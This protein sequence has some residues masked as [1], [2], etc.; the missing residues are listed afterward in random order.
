MGPTASREERIVFRHTLEG[1]FVRGLRGRLSAAQARRLEEA[2]LALHGELRASYPLADFERFLRIVA[3]ELY[4]GAPV[5]T[6]FR[7]LGEQLLAGY[8][9]TLVGKAVLSLLPLVG[10]GRTLQ[11]MRENFRSANN[12]SEMR[13]TELGPGDFELWTNEGSELRFLQQGLIAAA[14]RHAGAQDVEVEVVRHEAASATL[15]VR[16]RQAA[17]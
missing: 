13:L 9:E 3:E 14:M 17:R 15:R 8:G 12:Y 11:R 1:L 5:S 10:P 4:P 16:W 7:K 6:A 2:G